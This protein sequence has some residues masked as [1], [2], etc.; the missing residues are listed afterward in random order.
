VE[1]DLQLRGTSES[2]PPCTH[3]QHFVHTKHVVPP[4]LPAHTATHDT[5]CNNLQQN[6]THTAPTATRPVTIAAERLP[7]ALT[8]RETQSTR[9]HCNNCHTLQQLQHTT[10]T[11]A[12]C[13]NCKTLQHLQHTATHCNTLQHTATTA[14]HYKPATLPI[15]NAQSAFSN[16]CRASSNRSDFARSSVYHMHCNT[17]DTH[18]NNRNTLQQPQRTATT[19]THCNNRSTLQQPQHYLF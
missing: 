2:S 19:A 1:N 3:T 4:C 9:T 10:T 16:C 11:A 14:T 12:H 13:T 7:T 17:L 15:L 6:Y 5:N 18:C 8:S